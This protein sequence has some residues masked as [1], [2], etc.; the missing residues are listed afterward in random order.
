MCFVHIRLSLH[1]NNEDSMISNWNNPEIFSTYAFAYLE[2]HG[3]EGTRLEVERWAE[4]T[5][6]EE[7]SQEEIA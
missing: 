3:K 4:K 7:F 5:F 1:Y 2:A 6:P